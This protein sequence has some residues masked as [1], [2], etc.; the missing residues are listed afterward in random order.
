MAYIHTILPPISRA[1]STV[2]IFGESGTGKEL[3]ART[4]HHN[5]D[6]AQRPMVTVNCT[7]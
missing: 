6:R 5:S 1:E 3:L 7:S 2:L 4:I